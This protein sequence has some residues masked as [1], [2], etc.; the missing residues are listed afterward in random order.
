MVDLMT[1]LDR[2]ELPSMLSGYFD[3]TFVLEPRVPDE[4]SGT[5]GGRFR[6]G[7]FRVHIVISTT[8]LFQI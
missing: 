1:I 2:W 4:E 7:P 5:N 3:N 6:A 8:D